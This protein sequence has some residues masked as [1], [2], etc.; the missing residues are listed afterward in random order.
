MNVH[1]G[2]GHYDGEHKSGRPKAEKLLRVK[3]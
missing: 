2:T 1:L 3:P